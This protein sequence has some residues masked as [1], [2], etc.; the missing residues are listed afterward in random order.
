VDSPRRSL[1]KEAALPP[2]T[3]GFQGEAPAYRTIGPRHEDPVSRAGHRSRHLLDQQPL[4]LYDRAN[5]PE[6]EPSVPWSL[7]PHHAGVTE[8]IA[9]RK[10]L[11]KARAITSSSS[12][13]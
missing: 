11:L 5:L 2:T 4:P 12:W 3:I 10:T 9:P 1:E 6:Q 13:R 8:Q 7:A